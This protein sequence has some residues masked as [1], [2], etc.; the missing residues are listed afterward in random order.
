MEYVCGQRPPLST[1][2]VL[3]AELM[4]YN[5]LVMD[6]GTAQYLDSEMRESAPPAL[7]SLSVPTDGGGGTNATGSSTNGYPWQGVPHEPPRTISSFEYPRPGQTSYGADRTSAQQADT[8]FEGE[9]PPGGITDF[10]AWE[11]VLYEN[12]MIVNQRFQS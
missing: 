7:L 6:I 9:W 4:V 11:R 3:P 8:N 12:F 1:S 5:D 10:G 2:S